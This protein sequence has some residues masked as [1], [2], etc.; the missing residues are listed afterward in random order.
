MKVSKTRFEKSNQLI[1]D[2]YASQKPELSKS[3]RGYPNILEIFN[4]VF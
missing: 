2:R 3:N 1:I 4:F